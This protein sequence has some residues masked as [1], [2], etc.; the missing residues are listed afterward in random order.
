M[1]WLRPVGEVVVEQAEIDSAMAALSSRG[2]KVMEAALR[3]IGVL[4]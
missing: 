1:T 3:R 4:L 2:L